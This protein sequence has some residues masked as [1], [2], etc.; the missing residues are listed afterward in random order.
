MDPLPSA[1]NHSPS[2]ESQ[3]QALPCF[4]V[5]TGH[6]LTS[7][8]RKVIGSAQKWSRRGFLQHGSILLN[9]DPAIWANVV[10]HESANELNAVGV[11]EL[12]EFSMSASELMQSLAVE[13]Q[14]AMGGPATGRHLSSFEKTSAIGLAQTK[15]SNRDW[16]VFRRD[17]A[18]RTNFDNAI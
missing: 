7:R 5:P 12:L 14:R 16:N 4:A 8:G 10:G 9:I 6:E 18:M 1:S 17:L 3:S 2:P 15:Y 11:N 13:F